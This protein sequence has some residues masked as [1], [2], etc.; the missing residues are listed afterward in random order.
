MKYCW[1]CF[2]VCGLFVS[3]FSSLFTDGNHYDDRALTVQTLSLFN[4]RIPSRFSDLSWKGDWAFRRER[5]N[6][7]DRG[8]RGIKPD[9]LIIQEAMSKKESPSDSDRNILLA[10]ALRDY[11]WHLRVVREYGDTQ[12][13]EAMAVATSYPLKVDRA[14]TLTQK[15][16]WDIGAGGFVTAT[17]IDFDNYPILVFNVQMPVSSVNRELWYLFVRDKIKERIKEEGLCQK[18]IIVAGYLPDSNKS[19]KYRELL[20]ALGLKD[21]SSGFCELESSCYT[22]TPINEIFM[23]TIGDER[24]SRSDRILVPTS[25]VVLSSSPNFRE[26]GDSEMV[27]KFGLTKLWGTQR[28]GWVANM[29]FARCETDLEQ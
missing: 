8:L 13:V 18:R 6:L 9:L 5:L 28:Y 25:T 15:E 4:Q 29:R 20:T 17:A 3:C 26:I 24:P 10:G 14:R 19:S 12:E 16:L 11:D 7:I 21:A 1:V 22:S 27:K 23:A 2:I